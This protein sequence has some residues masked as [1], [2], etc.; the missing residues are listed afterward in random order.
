[1]CGIAALGTAGL[2]ACASGATGTVPDR[3]EPTGVPEGRLGARQRPDRRRRGRGGRLATAPST[4]KS[5]GDLL[6]G[7][8]LELSG[9]ASVWAQSQLDALTLLAESLNAGGGGGRPAIRLIP[10]DN[11]SNE[12]KS[13]VVARRLI[14][15]DRVTAVIGGRHDADDDADRARWRTRARTPLVSIGSA[16]AIVEPV[17]ERRWVFKTPPQLARRR[18]PRCSATCARPG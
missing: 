1:M 16:N 10:Y 13:L 5:P 2:T 3:G 7:V 6:V 14:E 4:A 8:N 17:E 11:E 12:A 18:R 9:P 15:E